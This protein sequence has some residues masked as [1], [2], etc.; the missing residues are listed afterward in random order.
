MSCPEKDDIDSDSSNEYCSK[1]GFNET[2]N[3]N[4]RVNLNFYQKSAENEAKIKESQVK[5]EVEYDYKDLMSTC[6][7]EKNINSKMKIK[8]KSKASHQITS[9]L[10]SNQ[11]KPNNK[12][13][14]QTDLIGYYQYK[15]VFPKD[16]TSFIKTKKKLSIEMEL[17]S[18]DGM[19][20]S[21]NEVKTHKVKFKTKKI[22]VFSLESDDSN[23]DLELVKANTMNLTK[24]CL[25][26][27]SMSSIIYKLEHGRVISEVKED[28]ND[29]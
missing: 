10:L 29:E 13:S 17:S 16:D 5:D 4:S 6:N 20:K 25:R 22:D 18:S 28:E 24:V 2:N 7:T 27:R 1:P 23:E 12:L 15:D 9:R 8:N 19:R 3:E 26:E 21:K 11:D 14:N